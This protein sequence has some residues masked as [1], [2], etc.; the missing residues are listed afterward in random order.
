MGTR[1]DHDFR[2]NRS[3]A[4][5]LL[6]KQA[7]VHNELNRRSHVD[8]FSMAS[9]GP[10]CLPGDEFWLAFGKFEPPRRRRGRTAGQRAELRQPVPAGVSEYYG[11][12]AQLAAVPSLS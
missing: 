2:A 1:L 4:G 9:V 8:W 3:M 5:R 12:P 11:C 6:V 7:T 10:I